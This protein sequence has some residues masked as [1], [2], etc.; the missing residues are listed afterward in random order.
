MSILQ[1]EN[2]MFRVLAL[3]LFLTDLTGCQP[4][5]DSIE[6]AALSCDDQM[7]PLV[8]WVGQPLPHP[9]TGSLSV[10]VYD[11]P[12]SKD[13][14][15]WAIVLD[16][17]QVVARFD[18]KPTNIASFGLAFA[19][20]CFPALGAQGATTENTI[21][22]NLGPSKTTRPT[23]PVLFAILSSPEYFTV[24]KNTVDAAE[25]FVTQEFENGHICPIPP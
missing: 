5:L 9:E 19:A 4:T 15:T 1:K 7:P 12:S 3:L 6:R 21:K 14:H 10:F 20:K 2:P 17:D 24:L 13:N 25:E 16:G 23:G 18:I 8:T 22:C 11:S